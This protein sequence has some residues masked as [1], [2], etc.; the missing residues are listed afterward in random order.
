MKDT[1]SQRNRD[2][3]FA[4]G[5]VMVVKNALGVVTG[6]SS[7]IGAATARAMAQSGARVVLLARRQEALD[8]LVAE[9]GSAS[10]QAWAFV[11]DLRDQTAVA[12]VDLAVIEGRV[13]FT[14][15]PWLKDFTRSRLARVAT[16]SRPRPE[17][18][19]NG[20]DADLAVSAG[21]V[22]GRGVGHL[23]SHERRGP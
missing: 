7:G 16:E 14:S 9:I 3:A 4:G 1:Q 6:A 11:T 20:D 18:A 22:T 19:G 15:K 10:R 12:V 5:D 23:N 8:H 2:Q 21:R 17:V 13:A